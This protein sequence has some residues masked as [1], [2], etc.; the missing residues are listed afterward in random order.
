M[1]CKINGNNKEIEA[2]ITV[3]NLLSNK[4]LLEDRVV[5]ELNRTIIEKKAFPTTVLSD[6][7]EIE[8]LSFVGG[9]SQ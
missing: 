7:D 5:V 9:G 8:I 2:G 6:G 3:S 1:N 4:G